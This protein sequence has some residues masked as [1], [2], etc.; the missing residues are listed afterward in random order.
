[1]NCVRLFVF[2]LPLLPMV[3]AEAASVTLV[4]FGSSAAANVYGLSGWS[5][6]LKSGNL[7]YTSIGNGGVRAVTDPGEYGDFRGVS[8]T[9]RR[10]SRGERVVV[11]WFN[12]SDETVFFTSRISFSDADEPSETATDGNW[13]TM[14]RF[15]DYRFTYSEIQPHGTAKTVFNVEN[16]GVH[17][18]DGNWSLVNINLAVEWGSTYQKR[19]LV[20]DK[21][22]LFDDA[23][24]FPPGRPSGLSA[25]TLSDSKI[26]L[27]WETLSDNAGVV[28]YLVYMDGEIEGYSR[29]PADTVVFLE[30]DREYAFCVS[31]LDAAGNESGLS[32]PV[33]ART[34]PFQGGAD[35]VRPAGFTYLGAFSLPETFA[36]GGEAVAFRPDADGGSAS[37]GTPGSLFVTNLNQP[38]T[39]WVGEVSIP[40]PVVSESRTLSDLPVAS[41]LREPVNIRPA[42]IDA[43]NF[44]DIWR[45][46]LAVV[47]EEGRIYSAW[48][49]HYTVTGEKHASISACDESDPAGGVR[50]GAWMVGNADAPPNDAGAGDWLFALPRDWAGANCDGRFLVSGRCRD[51][52]LSGLGPTLYAFDGVGTTPPAAGSALPATALLQYGPV[53]ASDN[54]HFPR[55][56]DGYNHADEWRAAIWVTSGGPAAVALMGNKALGHNWYG[57]TGE[58]MRHDWVIA[59][60]PY[61]EFQVTDPDGKGWRSHSRR[62]MIVLYDPDDLA[63]VAAGTLQPWDPQ[64][65]AAIRIPGDLF[66]GDN[67]EIFSATF[68]SENRLLYAVEFIREAEG[69]LVVHVW[70]VDAVDAVQERSFRPL[71][72]RLCPNHPNPFNPLTTI[73]FEAAAAGRVRL[74]VADA[75]GRMVAVIADGRYAGGSHTVCFDASGLASG[76]YIV[77]MQAEGFTASRKIAL[78]K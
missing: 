60:V 33:S 43:W 34:G 48:S 7:S 24:T 65:Y 59:D 44:V 3:A 1:M 52:G 69:S 15:T 41:V 29:S 77:R 71:E 27:T 31:A 14:R 58:K 35:L 18:T 47:P 55:S 38:E 72:F 42:D 75:S 78:V 53:E 63:A 66:F 39:G 4:D 21:I 76:V 49:Y 28:E 67:H 68:D 6:P 12:D 11:T 36:W 50:H 46:G 9:S 5:A 17:K 54:V 57:Y 23:D 22:E 10:F 61:P 25:T 2:A 70:R 56:I 8:G 45:T 20:C 74:E 73:R 62:P 51:G 64:P 40:A 16:S 19:F 30:P 26:R 13:Y 37:D 32:D